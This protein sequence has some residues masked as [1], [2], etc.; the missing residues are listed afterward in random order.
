MNEM[1]KP[2]QTR[3]RISDSDF[4]TACVENARSNDNKLN[5]QQLADKFGV[6]RATIKQKVKS[7]NDL[8]MKFKGEELLPFEFLDLRHT[9]TGR[10]PRSDEE[11]IRSLDTLFTLVKGD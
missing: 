3:T 1:A 11:V 6:N 5:H 8:S 9:S 7:L 2:Q 10:A 4:V